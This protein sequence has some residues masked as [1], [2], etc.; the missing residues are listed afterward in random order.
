MAE[1]ILCDQGANL[2]L[3]CGLFMVV[4]LEIFLTN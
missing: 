3:F 2:L 1:A 4:M